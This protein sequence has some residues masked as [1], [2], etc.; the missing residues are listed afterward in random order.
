MEPEGSLPCSEESTT[1]ICHEPDEISLHPYTL[2]FKIRFNS[3]LSL[4]L[5]FSSCLF[6]L[7]FPTKIL[8]ALLSNNDITKKLKN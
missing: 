3:V 8:C 2:L 4:Q 1:G 7:G 6:P 5:D